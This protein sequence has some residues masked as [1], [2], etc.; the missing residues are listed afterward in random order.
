MLH[1]CQPD[2]H[3]TTYLNRVGRVMHSEG[4]LHVARCFLLCF[5]LFICPLSFAQD[6]ISPPMNEF[7]IDNDKTY[8]D[9]FGEAAKRILTNFPSTNRECRWDWRS[10]HCEPKCS[11]NFMP[12]LGD[13]H[14]GRAC[15]SVPSEECLDAEIRLNIYLEAWT[16]LSS[17]RK[18]LSE[19]MA[20]HLSRVQESTC[21]RVAMNS[22]FPEEQIPISWQESLLCRRGNAAYSTCEENI[23]Q[24]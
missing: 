6:A 15:R 16:R 11:C 2:A 9:L 22:C 5:L 13:Y 24:V 3:W 19:R 1:A 20:T 12:R 18:K 23:E 14:L 10:L 8:L 4:R 17:Y 7:P 21:K